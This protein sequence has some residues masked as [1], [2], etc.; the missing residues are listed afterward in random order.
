MMTL[1]PSLLTI[2]LEATRVDIISCQGMAPGRTAIE[3]SLLPEWTMG[4]V[5]K[6]MDGHLPP[7][8]SCSRAG[9]GIQEPPW[10]RI[11]YQA[12]VSPDA[13]ISDQAH[14]WRNTHRS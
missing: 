6:V 11:T 7:V 9:P 5:F 4:S 2:T 14:D 12:M 10:S 13:F 8:H 1:T 3:P